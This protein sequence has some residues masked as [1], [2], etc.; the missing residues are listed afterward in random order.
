MAAPFPSSIDSSLSNQIQINSSCSSDSDCYQNG[1]VCCLTPRSGSSFQCLYSSQCAIR[2][3]EHHG[4]MNTKYYSAINY[5]PGSIQSGRSCSFSEE[6]ADS[7]HVCHKEKKNGTG[8][9]TSYSKAF[10]CNEKAKGF[11]YRCGNQLYEN[12]A[13][14]RWISMNVPNMLLLE[15]TNI[16]STF[17]NVSVCR[18]PVQKPDLRFDKEGYAFGKENSADCIVPKPTDNVPRDSFTWITPTPAEQEDAVLAI[19]GLG[20]RVIRTYTL[21]FGAT[22]HANIPSPTSA[23]EYYEPAWIAFDYAI[24][25]A[26]KHGIRLIV[27]LINHY[28]GNLDYMGNFALLA[29]MRSVPYDQFYTSSVTR[30]DLKEILSFLLNRRNTITGIQYFM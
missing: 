27:P 16:G 12:G 4:K 2:Y 15:D 6:C 1:K 30:K 10:G 17:R 24:A 29:G 19:K 23:I 14:F 26:Q 7:T 5:S 8:V 22:Y 9:C 13:L 25:M 21:G 28:W 3:G 20:G 11:V 18:L